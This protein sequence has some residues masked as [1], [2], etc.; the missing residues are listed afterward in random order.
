MCLNDMFIL[1]LDLTVLAAIVL[2]MLSDN[3]AL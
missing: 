3:S 1:L 2:I